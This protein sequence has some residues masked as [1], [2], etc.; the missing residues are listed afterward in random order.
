MTSARSILRPVRRSMAARSGP[1][2][3][4]LPLRYRTLPAD[5][6]RRTYSLLRVTG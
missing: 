4:T 5:S 3:T 2:V 1:S 6:V